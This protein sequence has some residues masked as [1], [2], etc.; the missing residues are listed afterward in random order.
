[1]YFLGAVI[2][3]S[4]FLFKGKIVLHALLIAIIKT[5]N[6]LNNTIPALKAVRDL[7]RIVSLF[8]IV[9]VSVTPL[10]IIATAGSIDEIST[11]FE[12]IGKSG[13]IL[14]WAMFLLLF[15]FLV[16]GQLVQMHY[17]TT[18]EIDYEDRFFLIKY[19]V[20]SFLILFFSMWLAFIFQLFV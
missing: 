16:E 9:A 8:G 10:I 13:A 6:V 17:C 14:S 11:M 3:T 19:V 1:M 12:P 18:G 4:I 7:K 5:S 15:L 20:P 2:L